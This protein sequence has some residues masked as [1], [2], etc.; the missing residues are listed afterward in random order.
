MYVF[1][2]KNRKEKIGRKRGN[3]KETE[4]K[5]KEKYLVAS[6]AGARFGLPPL[7]K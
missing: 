7:I 5:K 2:R 4:N 3:K 1:K 6:Q